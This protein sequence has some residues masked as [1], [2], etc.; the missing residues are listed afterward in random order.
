MILITVNAHG[1]K[2]ISCILQVKCTQVS[3]S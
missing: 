2:M 3:S 1:C